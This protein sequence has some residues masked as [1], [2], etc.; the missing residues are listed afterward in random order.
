MVFSGCKSR[1][2]LRAFEVKREIFMKLLAEN[3]ILR[4][5]AAAFD[6]MSQ[7]RS[8]GIGRRVGLKNR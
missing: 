8:G 1:H 3:K 2:F 7:C 6:A 4:T 5:F